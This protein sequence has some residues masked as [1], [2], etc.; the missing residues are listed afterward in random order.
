MMEVVTLG[1]SGYATR[2]HLSLFRKDITRAPYD[3]TTALCSLTQHCSVLFIKDESGRSKMIRPESKSQTETQM[4]V[5][6]IGTY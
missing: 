3:V 1:T 6:V 2:S 5:L 4:L